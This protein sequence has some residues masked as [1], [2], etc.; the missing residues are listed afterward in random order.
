MLVKI[1]DLPDGIDGIEATGQV[2]KEDYETELEPMIREARAA[3]RKLRLVYRFGPQFAGF[4]PSA[5]WEDAMVGL[6]SMRDFAACAIVSDIGWLRESTRVVG[7]L[8]P[9]PVRIFADPDLHLAIDWLGAIPEGRGVRHHLAP[10][11]GVVV[12]EVAQALRAQDFDELAATVDPWIEEHGELSGVVVHT[13]GLPRWKDLRSF[14]TYVRFL[15][16]HHRKVRRIAL[17]AGGRA[18]GIASRI[19]R[20]FVRPE[21]E[22][23]GYDELDRAIEWAEAG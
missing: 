13:P 2:T 3:G 16:G 11:K 15:R 14:L 22:R 17:S 10:D 18:A 21:V 9:F 23:F 19:G 1:Q 7:A 6:R 5:A 4:T 12:V 8:L 20:R